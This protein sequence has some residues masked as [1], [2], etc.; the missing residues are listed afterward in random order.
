MNKS[1][2]VYISELHKRRLR[3]L[4]ANCG[5]Y[6]GAYVEGL[7]DQAFNDSGELWGNG[8][9]Q[10]QGYKEEQRGQVPDTSPNTSEGPHGSVGKAKKREDI[11]GS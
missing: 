6:M 2:I 9:N 1:T 4:A 11:L 5:K 3:I 10:V 7:I 8:D